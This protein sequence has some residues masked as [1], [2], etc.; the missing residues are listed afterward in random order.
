MKQADNFENPTIRDL[1]SNLSNHVHAEIEDSH[2]VHFDFLDK[3]FDQFEEC[4]LGHLAQAIFAH[5]ILECMGTDDYT[6]TAP[7]ALIESMLEM[8]ESAIAHMKQELKMRRNM[9]RGTQ[10]SFSGMEKESGNSSGRSTAHL[11]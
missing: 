2:S 4:E 9:W 7:S 8:Y 11:N 6:F 5:E 3:I 10:N 1:V